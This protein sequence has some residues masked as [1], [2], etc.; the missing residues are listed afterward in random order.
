MHDFVYFNRKFIGRFS[1]LKNALSV[2]KDDASSSFLYLRRIIRLDE[3]GQTFVVRLF[4]RLS[5]VKT[6]TRRSI[7]LNEL[8]FE[9]HL[10]RDTTRDS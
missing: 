7:R 1:I 10:E 6:G 5:S 8:F 2:M 4:T 3:L 9:M